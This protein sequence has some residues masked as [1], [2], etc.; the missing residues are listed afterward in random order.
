MTFYDLIFPLFVFVMGVSIPLSLA[1]TIE[2]KAAADG[3]SM[4]GSCAASS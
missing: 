4:C 3:Q 2:P 1:R